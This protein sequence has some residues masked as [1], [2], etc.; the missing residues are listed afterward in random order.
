MYWILGLF[1]D[2]KAWTCSSKQYMSRPV[3]EWC[4]THDTGMNLKGAPSKATHCMIL[5]SNWSLS[6]WLMSLAHAGSM[7][8]RGKPYVYSLT[9]SGHVPF[10][11][12]F[13]T[14]Q[15]QHVAGVEFRGEE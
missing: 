6:H 2:S 7:G 8:P 14:I 3:S 10:P 15:F 12:V 9:W 1:G 5:G 4:D 13:L 11:K